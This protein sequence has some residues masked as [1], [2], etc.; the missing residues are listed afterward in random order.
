M[1]SEL[2]DMAVRELEQH[3]AWTELEGAARREGSSAA[4]RARAGDSDQD[5]QGQARAQQRSQG[6]APAMECGAL[7]ERLPEVNPSRAGA[8]AQG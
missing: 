5:A 4:A 1:D 2:E 7:A 6:R 8:G 3:A